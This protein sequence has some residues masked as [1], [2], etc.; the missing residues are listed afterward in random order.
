MSLMVNTNQSSLSAQRLLSN[1]T[2]GVSASYERLASG[3]RI[4]RAA[5][6]AAGLVISQRLTSQVQ[7][8]GQAGRNANDAISLA[9][10]AEGALDEIHTALQRLRV[11]TIQ[12][13]NGINAEEDID[14]LQREFD[15]M[16]ELINSVANKTEFSG[17]KLLDGT[18]GVLLFQTGAN[19]SQ[20]T[21]VALTDDYTAGV[22]GLDVEGLQLGAG[23][24]GDILDRIDDAIRQTDRG[25][26]VLGATQNILV[27]TIRNLA[28]IEE[29]VASSRSR[30]R[31]SDYAKET[32]ELTRT[33]ILQN[34]SSAILT[35]AN[36]RPRAA[37]A[38]L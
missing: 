31:D 10:V 13:E 24:S 33:Q 36:Q 22:N 35:Q 6:D 37:L 28:N 3:Y 20:Y 1:V 8:L 32:T 34:S 19:K 15:S 4:N 23:N 30:I 7:G 12:S 25:R 26:T 14:A 16:T 17:I 11:L 38:I 21:D 27:T 2:L 29:N 9:Q 18:A 5:D